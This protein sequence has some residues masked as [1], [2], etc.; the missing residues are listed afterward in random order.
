M[1]INQIQLELKTL[2]SKIKELTEKNESLSKSLKQKEN[3]INEL[4][5][6]LSNC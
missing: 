6:N 3:E 5:I 4:R 2:V 1:D